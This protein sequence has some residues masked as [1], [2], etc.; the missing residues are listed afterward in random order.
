VNRHKLARNGEELEVPKGLYTNSSCVSANALLSLR[1]SSSEQQE[2]KSGV[3]R[4]NSAALAND[5]RK[6]AN[7]PQARGNAD[8]GESRWGHRMEAKNQSGDESG[9]AE[10][11]TRTAAEGAARHAAGRRPRKGHL[12][13]S[14]GHK[15]AKGEKG[16][17]I[18]GERAGRQLAARKVQEK[19]CRSRRNG[20]KREVVQ[21]RIRCGEGNP[22]KLCP[23]IPP[24]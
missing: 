22:G 14:T 9:A 13:E 21:W 8:D 15:G 23:L 20:R 7:G 1:G 3:K 17:E 24:E 11:V 16:T 19:V 12:L 6:W 18:G 4:K 5:T 2:G 10:N